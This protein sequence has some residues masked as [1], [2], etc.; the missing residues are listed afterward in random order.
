M[1]LQ[2]PHPNLKSYAA[3]RY[4]SRQDFQRI[5]SDD[6]LQQAQ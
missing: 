5:S 6:C 1:L 3:C 2:S 4:V